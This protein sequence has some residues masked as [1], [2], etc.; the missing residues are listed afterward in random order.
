MEI[1][2]SHETKRKIHEIGEWLEVGTVNGFGRQFAGKDTELEP[3]SVA[4][5]T[6]IIGGG[7]ILRNVEIPDDIK[8]IMESGALIPSDSYEAIV[9]PYLSQPAFEGRP[10][11]LS[12]VGRMNGE[13]TGVMQAT[14][15]AGHTIKLV[16]DFQ[17]TREESQ[18]RLATTPKRGRADDTIDGLNKRLDFFDEYTVPVLGFYEQQ[19]LLITVD[20]MPE[21]NIVFNNFINLAH[22]RA[23]GKG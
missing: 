15:A 5:D 19:G 9:L 22:D 8:A 10:L 20:A 18:F 3:L 21:A 6:P 16:I 1:S 12:A 17:I 4:Y 2:Y 14:A 13:Q 11:L 23:T 7:D